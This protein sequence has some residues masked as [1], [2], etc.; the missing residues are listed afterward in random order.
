M[1]GEVAR[2]TGNL[3]AKRVERLVRAGKPGK[4]YDGA[5][6]RL[7]IE[8]KRSAYWVARYQINNVTRYMGLGSAKVFG[9][10]EARR[11]NRELVRQKLADGIDPL[12]ARQAERAAKLAAAAKAMTFSE[13]CRRFLKQHGVKWDSPKHRAQWGSTLKSY[14][15][16]IIGKLPVGEIDTPII[17]KV[18]EQPVKAERGPIRRFVVGGKAR[19]RQPASQPR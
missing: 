16:P 6:L 19:D 3:K 12:Q 2:E 9:L 13:A 8:S 7:E 1:E 10:I 5:G 15:E 4:H 14:A 17:L 11:R 18:L